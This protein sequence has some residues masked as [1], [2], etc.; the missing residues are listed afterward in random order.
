VTRRSVLPPSIGGVVTGCVLAL[1]RAIGEAAPLLLVA[2]TASFST[3]NSPGDVFSA[4]PLQ[5]YSWTTRPQVAFQV[6][7]AA[8]IMVLLG[9]V[10]TVNVI[11]IFIRNRSQVRW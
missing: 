4:L 7:A 2:V 1:S 5:I 6:N 8:A 9:I 3:P 10:L 11:A